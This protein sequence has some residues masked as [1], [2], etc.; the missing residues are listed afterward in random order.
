MNGKKK[1]NWLRFTLFMVLYA[2]FSLV[3]AS[4]ALKLLWDFCDNYERS[5]PS[6][7]MNEYVASLTE[8]RVKKLSVDFVATLDRNIQSE[9]E[10]YS[11]IWKCFTGGIQ[12]R[13]IASESAEDR[14]SYAIL[15][16]EQQLGTVTL[17]RNPGLQGEKSWSVEKE[18]YDFSFLIRSQ[19][20]TIP[21]HWVVMCGKRRL[22]VQYITDPR[23]HYSFVEDFYERG[24]PMPYLSEYEISN[25]IGDPRMT[26][27][28]PDGMEQAPF[29]LTDG[30]DQMPRAS[31]AT[32]SL[33]IAFTDQFVPLYINCLA[34]TQKAAGFNY[35]R[36]KPLLV[37]NSEIDKR[38]RGAIEGQVF[39]QSRATAIKSSTVHDVFDLGNTFYLIDLSFTV[40]TTTATG[41]TETDTDMFLAVEV[42]EDVVKAV[43]VMLY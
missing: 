41:H 4:V 42:E 40:D 29:V 11:E 18:E 19:C 35:A 7:R 17:V 22:G 26:F 39:A 33:I 12:Y 9:D 23:V 25:Y 27:F 13:R 8:K 36:I 2:L 28:D 43:M 37:P 6:R 24:F 34:N 1:G 20:F 5:L 38:L 10:A 15:N 30:R 16:G 21:E 14:V 31:K 3:V 32:S